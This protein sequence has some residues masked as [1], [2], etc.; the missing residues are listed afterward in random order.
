MKVVHVKEERNHMAT[1]FE[2][3]VSCPS[4]RAGAAERLLCRAHDRVANLENELTEFRAHSP[5]AKLNQAPPLERVRFTYAG[6]EL[7][8]ISE[9]LRFRTRGAFDCTAKSGPDAVRYPRLG[10]D[11]ETL[12]VWRLNPG[13]RLGFGAIGKGYALDQVRLLLL[14]EG[15]GDFLLSAGGSS[16]IISG[17]AAPGDPWSFGWSWQKDADGLPLGLP[18]THSSGKPVAIGVSGVEEQGNHLIDPRTRSNRDYLALSALIGHDSAARADALSTA[19]FITGFDQG[20][21]WMAELTESPAAAVIGADHVPRW[22]GIFQ[23]FWGGIA[24]LLLAI[25]LISVPLPSHARTKEPS[26]AAKRMPIT[27]PA[28]PIDPPKAAAIAEES[29][30]LDAAT[31]SLQNGEGEVDLGG[32]D[33][34][35]DSFLPYVVERNSLWAIPAGFMFLFVL[36]HLRK[37]KPQPRSRPGPGH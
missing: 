27:A 29:V 24:S 4:A 2:M 11:A 21:E 35:K 1:T 28:K 32:G 16:L 37:S 22:N 31:E 30:S 34:P 23:G 25:G 7:L 18:L 36:I 6:I 5:V 13:V 3:T 19:L 20:R 8:E 9:N 14:Q 10:W 12:E 17:F 26:V 15:F 33:S